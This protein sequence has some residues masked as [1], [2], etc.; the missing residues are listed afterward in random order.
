MAIT[1]N[2]IEYSWG[3]IT[4]KINGKEITGFKAISYS[5]A[6]E[7]EAV[8]GAGRHKLGMTRGKYTTEQGSLTAYLKQ[9]REI[10]NDLGDG[11]AD[12]GPFEVEVRYAEPGEDTH[13]DIVE[14][15]RFAGTSGGGE[16]G[17]SP[18]E[19]EMKFDYM[20]VKRDGN[21]LV[22]LPTA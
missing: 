6:V 9:E 13:I 18:L 15:C 16:E 3:S 7:R 8:Y 12:Y 5:D 21:Y 10:I 4:A 22:A 14:G 1:V 2:D 11:W 20:R 19:R 17:A